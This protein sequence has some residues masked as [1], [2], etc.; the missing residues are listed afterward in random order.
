V[1]DNFRFPSAHETRYISWLANVLRVDIRCPD[2]GLERRAEVGHVSRGKVVHDCHSCA[3]PG[4]PR[5]EMSADESGA[6][7]DEYS[8]PRHYLNSR[9]NVTDRLRS[10]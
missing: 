8:H 9:L 1:K 6:S 5:S 7:G 2:T 3:K 10:G 4:E